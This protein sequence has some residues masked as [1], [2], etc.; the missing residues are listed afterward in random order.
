MTSCFSCVL[1]SSEKQYPD[2]SLFLF[3]LCSNLPD[4]SD[5][6]TCKIKFSGPN[7][8]E[9]IK[10]AIAEDCFTLPVPEVITKTTGLASNSVTLDTTED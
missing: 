1:V 3:Q 7:V 10:E 2:P 5:Y 6:V 4:G 9:G 8:F